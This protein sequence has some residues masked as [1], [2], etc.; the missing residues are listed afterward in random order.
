MTVFPR[1]VGGAKEG[2]EITIKDIFKCSLSSPLPLHHSNDGFLKG[3][4]GAV[5]Q[6][7]KSARGNRP[8]GG[9]RSLSS[10]LSSLCSYIIRRRVYGNMAGLEDDDSLDS[11]SD[12]LLD[13]ECLND[14]DDDN[15]LL[16]GNYY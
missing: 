7:A 1:W 4:T 9:T 14:D 6:K 11:D 16:G 2:K 3:E 8:H 13:G 5:D 12:M 10:H 15:T